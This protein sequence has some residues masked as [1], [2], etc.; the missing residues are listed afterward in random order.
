[1]SSPSSLASQSRFD[2]RR[3]NGHRDI[4]VMDVAR[5]DV[6]HRTIPTQI[7]RKKCQCEKGENTFMAVHRGLLS[8]AQS[9]AAQTN[10]L[11]SGDGTSQRHRGIVDCF[12]YCRNASV[13]GRLRRDPWI[14]Y[15]PY[16]P[17]RVG[18]VVFLLTNPCVHWVA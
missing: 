18:L 6:G 4:R 16:V 17:Y 11:W 13:D 1:M 12:H 10:C 2:C 7:K 14:G 9:N 15:L 3:S 5:S 8:I